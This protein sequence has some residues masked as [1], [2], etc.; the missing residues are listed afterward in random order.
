[1]LLLTLPTYPKADRI[2]VRTVLHSRWLWLCLT[3]AAGTALRFYRI[4]AMSLWIDEATQYRMANA[5]TISEV[6]REALAVANPPLSQIINH[7]FLQFGQSDYFLRLPSVLF[8]VASLPVFYRVAIRIA[9][10]RAALVATAMFALSPFH[11][12][13][14]QEA[15]PYAQ[16][17]FFALLS[18]QFLIAALE[19]G[20]LARW[21]G[22]VLA[23]ILGLA[24]QVFM[25]FLLAAH[26][27]WVSTYHRDR[28]KPYLAAAT[29]AVLPFTWLLPF[30]VRSFIASIGM[31]ERTG[32]S[33]GELAYTFYAYSAGFSLGPSS[34]D[35]HID[36]SVSALLQFIPSILSVALVF[37][38]LCILGISALKENN[39]QPGKALCLYSICIAIGGA[40]LYALGITYQVRYTTVAFPFFCILAGVGLEGLWRNRKIWGSALTVGVILITGLSVHNYFGNERYFKSDIRAAV[41]NWRQVS[42]SEPLLSCLAPG[43]LGPTASRYIDAT[44]RKRFHE[45]SWKP[46]RIEEISSYLE[47]DK[48]S[49]IH[50]LIPQRA[51]WD[52]SLEKQIRQRWKVVAECQFTG[53]VL[54]SIIL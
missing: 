23:V 25:V 46:N 11:L 44:D 5:G 13:Y 35:L 37:G 54:I 21:T 26:L 22:Y 6:I 1:M 27:A 20:S 30:F 17:I 9:P 19:R 28:L 38:T 14:S 42:D 51:D 12:W 47:S 3:L 41:A 4:D 31:R 53:L 45:I 32:F 8:G 34:A 39:W 36:R 48:H 10:Q 50:V 43:A 16:L 49:R 7:L 33:A 29:G 15:R 52:R 40:A 24:T 2:S 18:T